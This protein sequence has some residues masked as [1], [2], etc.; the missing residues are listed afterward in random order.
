MTQEKAITRAVD[1]AQ[2]MSIQYD[3]PF[4]GVFSFDSLPDG[5][6]AKHPVSTQAV[7]VCWTLDYTW[8]DETQNWVDQINGLTVQFQ[9]Q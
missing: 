3:V 7:F 6:I 5:P 1:M 8:C 2:S 4:E 9:K